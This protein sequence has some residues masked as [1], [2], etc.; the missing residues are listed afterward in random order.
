MGRNSIDI[1]RRSF[2]DGDSCD[3]LE[4]LY[5]NG[6]FVREVNLQGDRRWK[7]SLS[8]KVFNLRNN[9]VNRR[10]ERSLEQGRGAQVWSGQVG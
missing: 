9:G 3:V 2:S 1:V 10:G 4:A 5:R 6:T 7:G 8:W